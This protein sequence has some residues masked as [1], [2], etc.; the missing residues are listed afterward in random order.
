MLENTFAGLPEPTT[1]RLASGAA[2]VHSSSPALS[3]LKRKSLAFAHAEARSTHGRQQRRLHRV[4]SHRRLTQASGCKPP[5]SFVLVFHRY[6]DSLRFLRPRRAQFAPTD[7][8]ISVDLAPAAGVATPDHFSRSHQP[9]IKR[10]FLFSFSLPSNDCRAQ[11]WRE[12][13][14]GCSLTLSLHTV[15]PL[16]PLR[17]PPLQSL[18]PNTSR[19]K[20]TQDSRF[21]RRPAQGKRRLSRFLCSPRIINST[22]LSLRHQLQNFLYS[23]A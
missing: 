23:S 2:C 15:H 14:R 13:R 5:S 9:S 19:G 21:M 16:R 7:A 22:I 11:L 10:H 1:Y 6:V 18:S 12:K 17:I 3:K 20:E 8:P 4:F